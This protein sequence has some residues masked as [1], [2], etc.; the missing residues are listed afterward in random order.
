MSS[1]NDF[2]VVL[3][4][5]ETGIFLIPKYDSTG[6][7]PRKPYNTIIYSKDDSGGNHSSI[8]FVK[9]GNSNGSA[10]VCVAC[11]RVLGG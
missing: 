5:T 3:F 10:C 1:V 8:C 11:I 7:K 6:N 9:D 4:N 2:N